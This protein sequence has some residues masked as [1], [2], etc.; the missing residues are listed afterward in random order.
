MNLQIALT[1]YFIVLIFVFLILRFIY[2]KAFSAFLISVIASQVVLTILYPPT[3]EHLSTKLDS[4][5]TLYFVI[6]V[7]GLVIFIVY[8]LITV[9][10]DYEESHQTAMKK[11]FL[12]YY[13][14][15][16]KI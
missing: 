14:I 7:L 11:R 10:G 12:P 16:D 15:E 4:S 1:F 13:I 5:T 6:Q 8:T 3:S 9:L 2:Y